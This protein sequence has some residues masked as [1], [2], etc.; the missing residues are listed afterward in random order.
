LEVSA[1]NIL[2]QRTARFFNSGGESTSHDLLFVLHGY[3]MHAGQFIK[4]FDPIASPTLKIVAPEG[5]SRFYRRGFDGDV[6]ASWMTRED[7]LSEIADQRYFLDKLY[8]TMVGSTVR[9]VYVLGFSQGTATASRW[10]SGNTR[11]FNGLLLWGGDFAPDAEDPINGLRKIQCVV[12]NQDPFIS[13]PL[14]EERCISLENR[15]YEVQR[16]IFEGAHEIPGT[17]LASTWMATTLGS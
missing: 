4:N 8:D 15:G 5:L 6:I 9:R 12:G 1:H 3:G 10:M 13:L 7:R 11:Q 17:V 2:V 16:T 14:F